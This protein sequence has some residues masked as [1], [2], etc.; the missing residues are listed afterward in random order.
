M[1]AERGRRGWQGAMQPPPRA[2]LLLFRSHPSWRPSLPPVGENSAAFMRTRGLALSLGGG[3]QGWGPALSVSLLPAPPRDF[4]PPSPTRGPAGGSHFAPFLSL[5]RAEVSPAPSFLQAGGSGAGRGEGLPALFLAVLPESPSAGRVRLIRCRLRR[6]RCPGREAGW[7]AEARLPAAPDEGVAGGKR[8]EEGAGG[9]AAAM[10]P[11]EGGGGGGGDGPAGGPGSGCLGGS[12]VRPRRPGVGAASRPAWPG[13]AAAAPRRVASGAA[14]ATLVLLLLWASVH[15][16]Q[17]GHLALYYR[18]G[19]LLS[20]VSGP[21]YHIMLPFVTTCISVQTTL[22]TDEV[23][24]VPCGTSGGV[25]IYIDR[26]EVVN[27]LAPHAV[28]DTVKKYTVDYDKTLIFNKVHH[29]L[30]QFCSTHTLQEVYIELFDQIDEHLKLALQQDLNAMAPGL[31]VQAV[32]VTKPKIPEA[33]R[34]NFELVEAEKTKFLIVTQQQKVVAK[35]A[36]T[37]R[38]KAVIEAEKA[39]QVAKIRCRQ[40]VMETLME[41]HISELEDAAFLARERAKA[42]ANYYTAQKAADSNKLKLTPAFLELM[43]YQAIAFNSTLYFGN[44]FPANLFLGSCAFDDPVARTARE[45]HLIS[46]TG[47]LHLRHRGE[48]GASGCVR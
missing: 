45:A 4:S 6:P 43:K 5:T 27:T 11:G 2:C 46:K 33:I 32:R 25:M 16:V 22:Q 21:G 40:K 8:P 42:D 38:K 14:S 15:T 17:E 12:V 1:E 19:A 44:S 41:K 23:K 48:R 10:M 47:K 34:R 35:E 36:E 3:I 29:E 37:E 28:Y 20:A 26:I 24:N 13:S 39:A 7:E 30:N 9:A 31:T 18:G